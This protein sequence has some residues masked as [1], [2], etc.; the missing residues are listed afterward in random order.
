[1]RDHSSVEYLPSLLIA[2]S[3]ASSLDIQDTTAAPVRYVEVT[4]AAGVDFRYENGA[5]GA[6][7]MPEPMGS[8]AAFFDYDGD[9][10]LDLFIVN[11]AFLTPAP[12]EKQPSDALYRNNRDGTFA[13]VTRTVGVADTS[14]GMGC[15]VGDY[16]GD[17]DADLYV[18]N[19]GP[20][21]LYRNNND[22]T[23]AEVTG[24]ARVGDP[25]WGTN[26]AFA[27]YDNDGDL[28]LYVANY[29]EFRPE[30]NK[31]CF[32]G[33]VPAY[34][35]PT[36]YPGQSGVLYRNNG[37]GTFTDVTAPA[38]LFT[39]AGR[40]LGTVFGD[41]DNDGDQ[42]IFV[43]ND[44]RPNFLFTNNGDG[45]FTEAGVTAGVAYDEDGV[46]GSVMGADMADYDN[47]GRPDILVATF[48]WRPNRLYHNDGGGFFS[49]V[50]Y[51]AQI[52][53]GSVPYLAMSASFL[54]YDNDGYLDILVANGHLDENVRDYDPAAS[55]AQKNQ[56][57]RNNGDGTFAEATDAA[58]PG[59][60]VER[61]SHG[62][63]LADYDNDGDTD[64]FVS[65]SATPRC[66]LL[67][68]DG[69]NRNRFLVVKTVGTRSNRD[70]IGARI[71]VQ[72][73]D[74]VQVRAVR[75]GYGYLSANDPR[76]FFGLGQHP[77]VDRL[78]VR[79][80]SG[81]VQV[82]ENIQA[83]QVLTITEESP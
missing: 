33:G 20:N 5:R 83:D 78:E 51:A 36:A 45:T 42:D 69:G 19:Y 13:E 12:G 11:G 55:Y 63:A 52:G 77:R 4:E 25:G 29:L 47:D 9:G 54:D 72:A 75:S 68:N 17:G 48:Q 27:D 56:L 70:G 40:Q 28:D 16:D 15:A 26:A 74:L 10:Y 65:D 18:T 2:L 14:Y 82:L 21:V 37:D 30:D 57:F 81:I 35:P 53:T 60:Q 64:I 73:G 24:E 76:A 61:V 80:P 50:T 1:M 34:C 8:G 66:T 62:A 59:F 32:Q 3:L 23:F 79:W 22:G 39:D 31:K 71:T 38:G 7:Y 44:L 46:A 6:K 49:D 41:Y 43:A 67:R 58:G